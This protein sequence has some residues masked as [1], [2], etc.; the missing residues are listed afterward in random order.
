[1]DF[2]IYCCKFGEVDILFGD[3]LG[4]MINELDNGDYIIEF[5]LGGFKNYGYQIVNGKICC[6]VCG[7]I[8]NVCGLKQLNYY[9][10]W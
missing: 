1:M 2:V 4:D 9:I 10:M 8:L 7:F 3:F 6:K 5:V